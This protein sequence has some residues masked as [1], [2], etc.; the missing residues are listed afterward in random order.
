MHAFQDR[1][2]IGIQEKGWEYL[3]DLLSVGLRGLRLKILAHSTLYWKPV[4]RSATQDWWG[5]VTEGYTVDRDF[6]SDGERERYKLSLE[7]FRWSWVDRGLKKMEGLRNLEVEVAV[8]NTNKFKKNGVLEWVK[9]LDMRLNK[10]REDA[11]KVKVVCVKE[12]MKVA[13]SARRK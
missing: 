11:Q 10:G 7:E 12:V 8:K 6:E 4:E 9:R 1:F 2:L 3:C 5:D 13:R